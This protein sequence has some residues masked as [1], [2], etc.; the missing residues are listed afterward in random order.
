M[1][2]SL[3]I[4]SLCLLL[5]GTW[6]CGGHKKTALATPAKAPV[7]QAAPVAQ[8]A[9]DQ[10]IAQA[11]QRF[12]QGER[13]LNLGHLEKAKQEFDASLDVLMAYQ[14]NHEPDAKIE[15]VINEL[16]DKIFQHEMAALKEGDGFT[17]RPLEPALIDELKDISTFPTPDQQTKSEVEQELK[18]I[19]YDLPVEVNDTVLS[20]IRIFQNA[21][22]KEFVGGLVRSGRYLDLMKQIFRE[23]GL[24][25]D[26]VYTA[27]IES[28]FK[29]NA[30]SRARAKGFWQ[31]ISGTAKR[32]D[33]KMDWWVDERSDF[34]RSTR[35]AA[36]YLK[37]LY[38]MF[39]DWYL[40][41]AGYNA[42]ENKIAYGLNRSGVDSFWELAQTRYI[43]QETKNYVPA[44]LAGMI[45]AKD[46][47]K[48]GFEED[49][50]MPLQFDTVPVDYTVDLRLVAE[51]AGASLEEIKLLNP[52]LSRLTTP[53]R[54]SSYTLRL[55]S[56]KKE[57]FLTE[58]SSIPEGKRITWRKHEVKPGETLTSI[59][60]IYR[61]SSASISS[62]NSFDGDGLLL[63]GQ[64]LVIPIGRSSVT[65][66]S[67]D[68]SGP[69]PY[70]IVR[71]GDTLS[72]I[73]SRSGTSIEQIC[74]LNNISNRHKLRVGERL[75]V[76]N[77]S[78][79]PKSSRTKIASSSSSRGNK[80]IVYQVKRGDT[81]FAIASNFKIDVSSIKRWN[82]L[83]KNSIRPGDSLT[84]Y[85]K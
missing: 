35:A 52:E 6:A 11:R 71:R 29:S 10:T 38:G 37:D 28:S 46:P 3:A 22:R 14:S 26:L 54:A 42:G 21:R 81:L 59:A 58:I 39:G 78:Y 53:S 15:A 31:F 72:R 75:A 74:E 79:S 67:D 8:S 30:Y 84:I 45:I 43:R 82:G 17:E 2:R 23:E 25:E 77:K 41:L 56:G 12:F 55:P 20:F 19:S 34:E 4:L 5:G 83:D 27:L 24:P 47:Q 64:K 57:T 16:E 32:Y 76:G 85:T 18:S 13:E 50:E 9:T 61:T 80:K 33:L 44:I 1:K 65:Y 36:R 51:C 69:K 73:A 48:Y 60:S 7:A 63:V 40:A 49:L 68:I 62:A 70:Y 66:P